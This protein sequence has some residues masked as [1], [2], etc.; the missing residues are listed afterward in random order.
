LKKGE[1]NAAI[2]RS[3]TPH[4]IDDGLPN[5]ARRFDEPRRPIDVGRRRDLTRIR[6][7]TNVSRC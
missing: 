4:L 1:A 5:P 6:E 3:A 2:N 7:T